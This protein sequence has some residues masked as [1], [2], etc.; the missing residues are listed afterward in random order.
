MKDIFYII[1]FA[2]QTYLI[3]LP[4]PS[5]H[6]QDN[7]ILLSTVFPYRL[8]IVD[9]YIAG[10]T[11]QKHLTF[12]NVDPD[13]THAIREIEFSS[14]GR[15]LKQKTT[16]IPKQNKPKTIDKKTG[17]NSPQFTPP[18]ISNHKQYSSQSTYLEEEKQLIYK[19]PN[20]GTKIR[21]PLREIKYF[22]PYFY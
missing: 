22:I 17:V 11:N 9:D 3:Y 5:I 6:M 13:N 19:L 10:F 18:N 1:L 2:F 16:I 8:I 12:K 4:K 20:C 21:S 14:L 15:I 7:N